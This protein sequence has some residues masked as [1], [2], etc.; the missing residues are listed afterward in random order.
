MVTAAVCLIEAFFLLVYLTWPLPRRRLGRWYLPIGIAVAAVAPILEM[1]YIFSVYS[2]SEAL[3]FWL[4]FPFLTVPLIITAWQ[5]TFDEVLLYCVG[6]TLL[7]PAVA[8]LMA[9]ARHTSPWFDGGMLVIRMA[10]MIG[11][12]YIVSYLVTQQRRQRQE[13]A[14]ANR[15][16]VRYAATQEQ[17]AT[18]R[19][20]NRLA[21]ELHDTLA[22]TL[23]ALTV[24]LDALT[25]VWGP[26][27]PRAQRILTHALTTARSGL[28]ETRRALQDLR[29]APLDD[30]GLVLVIRNV[31]ESAAERGGLTLSLDLPD[32][33][34]D[35]PAPV[36]NTFY[37][38]AQEALENA[39]THAAAQAVS[40]ALR[41]EHARLTLTVADDGRGFEPSATG[42]ERFGMRGMRE[43]AAD[44]GAVLDVVSGATQG[45]VV[46]LAYGVTGAD[47]G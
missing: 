37:R 19:E 16:L 47:Y 43:R 44:I 29:S 22:H 41:L 31:A 18:V 39:V 7:E 26:K 46:N 13:L 10:F 2:V 28:D 4:I 40:V 3:D 34:G 11:I 6:T 36:E 9:T 38:V 27:P 14:E 33:L 32:D 5:Y 20:R 30:L 35:L 45:T 12:G 21:R 23:S 15:K 8:A 25:A 17:L 42:E 24:Q 1:R